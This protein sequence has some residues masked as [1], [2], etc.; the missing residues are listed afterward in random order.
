[1]I[2]ITSISAAESETLMVR[3][4][5]AD[6]FAEVGLDYGALQR[7]L[8]LSVEKKGDRTLIRVS[9]EL[10]VSD[11]FLMLLI[12]VNAAG[13]RTVR[14]YALLLDPPLIGDDTR[15]AAI[16]A[17]VISAPSA[18]QDSS[19]TRA[20]TIQNKA[21]D[22]AGDKAAGQM[23]DPAQARSTQ[24]LVVRHGDTLSKV[25]REALPSGATLEQ[26][27]VAY[28]HANPGAFDGRNVH[29]MKA[30]SVLRVPDE[31][32]I[33]N[34]A[35][36]DAHHEVALQTA[37]YQRYRDALARSAARPAA[38]IA[39]EAVPLTATGN[40]SSSGGV[41]VQMNDAKAPAP[42]QD[43]LTLSAP[44]KADATSSGANSKDVLDKLAADHGLAGRS[45][46]MSEDFETAIQL[47]ATHVR[48][49]SALFGART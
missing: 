26:A 8:R 29:R 14:Q 24:T 13:N 33:K 5:P 43:R 28:L 41:S 9:S 48:V 36:T 27:L 46:G 45:M 20:S 32:A 21:S 44:G 4:A 25:A 15:S 37:D 35:A 11:P 42:A 49:G 16:E 18:V 10:L 2:D 23:I 19:A 39:G 22:K 31:Q 30:G 40:R 1:M 38:H 6:M 34:M 17:P 7:A 12:E 47:G 3:L